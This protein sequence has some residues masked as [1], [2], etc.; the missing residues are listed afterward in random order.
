VKAGQV[1]RQY[2]TPLDE[3]ADCGTYPGMNNQFGS[4]EDRKGNKKSDMHFDVVQEGNPTDGSA[5]GAK[6]GEEQ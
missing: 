3:A 2:D 6:D 5:R 1:L 4:D